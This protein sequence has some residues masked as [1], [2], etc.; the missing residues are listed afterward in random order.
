MGYPLDLE[1]N[2]GRVESFTSLFE[3]RNT[4]LIQLSEVEL[5]RNF[6]TPEDIETP[7]GTA[8]NLPDFS[9]NIV[10]ILNIFIC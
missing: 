5:F 2:A 7:F 8:T 6:K 4:E 10:H 3:N 1:E 9:M